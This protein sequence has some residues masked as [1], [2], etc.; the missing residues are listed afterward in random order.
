MED[1]DGE[2]AAEVGCLGTEGN[3]AILARTRASLL[4]SCDPGD[5]GQ[6]S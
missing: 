3:R 1:G 5:S 6:A 2:A 4:G